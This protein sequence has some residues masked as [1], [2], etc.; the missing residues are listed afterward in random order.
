MGEDDC[1]SL[2]AY[3]PGLVLWSPL[4]L[5]VNCRVDRHLLLWLGNLYRWRK[6]I[7][8]PAVLRLKMDLASHP[9][10]IREFYDS[11]SE[12]T[13]KQWLWRD[14]TI[15]KSEASPQ[16]AV[17]SHINGTWL[18]WMKLFT[19]HIL[20]NWEMFFWIRFSEISIDCFK[21]LLGIIEK[22]W[23]FDGSIDCY[24]NHDSFGYNNSID[25]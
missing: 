20:S 1:I 23:N 16:D 4:Q 13:W 9:A 21:K 5:R 2:L 25:S 10:L 12:W 11:N 7:F 18:K 8:K 19:K 15:L 6:T 22:I 17:A 24:K 14:V 3:A